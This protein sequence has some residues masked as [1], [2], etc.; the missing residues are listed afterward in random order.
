ME[1]TDKTMQLRNAFLCTVLTAV[2][3][4][5]VGILLIISTM[6]ERRV[7]VFENDKLES[8]KTQLRDNPDDETL[9][10]TVRELDRQ[11]RQGYIYSRELTERAR[12]LLVVFLLAFIVS[13]KVYINLRIE[14]EVPDTTQ[15]KCIAEQTRLYTSWGMLGVV[16]IFFVGSLVFIISSMVPGQLPE[17]RDVAGKAHVETNSDS[18]IETAASQ[19]ASVD[20]LKQNWHRFRGF[21]G[22]GTANYTNIPLEI[23]PAGGKNIL[24]KFEPELPGFNS[25]IIFGDK[26]F[27]AGANELNRKVYCHNLEDGKLLWSADVKVSGDNSDTVPEVMD[28]TGLAA[29]TMATDGYRVYSIFANGDLA[30]HDFDGKEIWAMNL[31]IPES[32]YG[33]AASLDVWHDNVLVQYDSGFDPDSPLAKMISVDGPTGKVDWQQSRPVI[34]SWT[35]PIVDY[36]GGKWQCI[37]VSAPWA[38]SYDPASGKELWRFGELHGDTAPSPVVYKDMTFI[39]IPYESIAA[40]NTTLDGDISETGILWTGSDG[41]PDATTPALYNGKLWLLDSYGTITCYNIEDGSVIYSDSIDGEYYSSPSIVGD[42][43]ICFS[44][45]GNGKYS[46]LGTG[47]TFELLYEAEFGEKIGTSPAFA[48]GKMIIRGVENIYCIGEK[49]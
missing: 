30:C 33:F 17:N 23:D 19:F 3:C 14:P 31:G 40:V 37:T 22:T 47:E 34:N 7:N 24:W 25:I 6:N 10:W 42:K 35:S 20:E 38:I 29:C 49:K 12:Y 26:F 28:D 5:A 48:D 2:A 15:C 27:Y 1:N 44:L 9:Q 46:V 11:Y 36:T 45:A 18:D 4:I 21:G 43:L 41:I 8:A 16:I 32:S 13:A 39:Q